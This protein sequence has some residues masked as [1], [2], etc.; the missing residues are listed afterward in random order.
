MGFARSRGSL[1]HDVQPL[2]QIVPGVEAGDHAPV[3]P[4][5][6]HQ[7]DGPQVS[8]GVAQTRAFDEALDLGVHVT[9]VG[10]VDRK[11]DDLRVAHGRRRSLVEPF[12]RVEQI[13]CVHLTQFAF[14]L[15]VDDHRASPSH[16]R[17][18][19]AAA[20]PSGV[21]N[22]AVGNPARGVLA[23]FEDRSDVRIPRRGDR[24]Q[25]QRTRVLQTLGGIAFRQPQ[26]RRRGL[27]ALLVEAFHGEQPADHG[28]AAG[29]YSPGP[30]LA[31]F[32]VP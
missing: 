13:G 15:G 23:G 8:L 4:A 20:H 17:V 3:E 25:R 29:A 19:I 11:P 24:P 26:D 18:V 30:L 9:G 7:V 32:P 28:G 16:V 6:L 12:E 27:H 31:T 2:S 21:V 14:G 1:E 10:V 22:G 5:F